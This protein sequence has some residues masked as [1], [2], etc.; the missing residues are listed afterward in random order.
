LHVFRFTVVDSI[1]ERI[2]NILEEKRV[3]F[4][5]YVNKAEIAEIPSLSLNDLKKIINL[6]AD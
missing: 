2:V 5:Q 3:L 4:E 1:E 6:Q